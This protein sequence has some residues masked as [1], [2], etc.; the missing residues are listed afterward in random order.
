ML[1]RINQ[2]RRRLSAEGAI[3]RPAGHDAAGGIVEQNLDP[4]LGRESHLDRAFA[5]IGE[6]RP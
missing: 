2:E 3:I 5:A 1:A 4:L 6:V